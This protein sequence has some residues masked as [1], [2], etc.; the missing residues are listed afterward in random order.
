MSDKFEN[1]KF[2]F[3]TIVGNSTI[4]A[5]KPKYLRNRKELIDFSILISIQK[6]LILNGC[7]LYLYKLHPFKDLLFLYSLEEGINIY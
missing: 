7:K 1:I 5:I 4:K 6:I 3:V 2:K